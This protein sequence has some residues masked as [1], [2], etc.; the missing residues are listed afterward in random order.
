LTEIFLF[1]QEHGMFTQDVGATLGSA[2]VVNRGLW[3]R[4]QGQ[5]RNS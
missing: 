1:L 5:P 2:L 4:R 3:T